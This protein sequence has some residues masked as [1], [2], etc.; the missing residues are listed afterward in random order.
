[1]GLYLF[2][3]SLRHIIKLAPRRRHFLPANLG[4]SDIWLGSRNS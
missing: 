2:I 3:N 1:M 4:D